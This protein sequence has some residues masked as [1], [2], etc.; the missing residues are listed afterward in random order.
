MPD[1]TEAALKKQIDSGEIGNVYVLYGDEK[2]LIKRAAKRIMAKSGAGEF[3]EF[4]LN[5]FTNMS[6]AESIV[7]SAVALPL[8]AE[9]KCTV[10]SDYN[11]DE[12]KADELEQIMELVK[13]APEE[14]VIVFY[15]PTLDTEAKKTAKWKKFLKEADKTGYTVNFKPK[16]KSYLTRLIMKDAERAG[17]SISKQN[18]GLILEYVG[19]DLTSILNETAKLTAFASGGEITAE[20]IDN[21]VAKS[22]EATAFMLSNALVWGNYEKAYSHMAD[23]F[24]N[25]EEPIAI[26]GALSMAYVDMY[27]VRAA[28]ESGEK[29]TAPMQ[30]GEYRGREF[31]LDKAAK[32]IRGISTESLKESLDILLETDIKLKSSRLDSRII[33]DTMIAKLLVA[34]KGDN[35]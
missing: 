24:Y 3:S 33:M 8:F 19:S 28:L 11:I 21:M 12:K 7:D 5:E 9:R 17:C 18:A 20:M 29:A 15:Y 10:I 23:L 32:N 22:V 35:S 30:Y 16:D 1:I 27:R 31:R 2:Y 4:N 26:I 13:A 14:T 34:A 25:R 6:S